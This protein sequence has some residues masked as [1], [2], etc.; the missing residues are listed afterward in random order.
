AQAVTT[1]DMRYA[2]EQIRRKTGWSS[3]VVS[4][5]VLGYVGEQGNDLS[6]AHVDQVQ[7]EKVQGVGAERE[8]Q[9]QPTYRLMSDVE[10]GVD[11]KDVMEEKILGAEVKLTLRE[12][13]RIIRQDLRDVVIQAIRKKKQLESEAITAT[14]GADF[15]VEGE[16]KE[17]NVQELGRVSEPEGMSRVGG[18]VGANVVE[19]YAVEAT[20]ME[21]EVLSMGGMVGTGA[22]DVGEIGDVGSDLLEERWLGRKLL[23]STRITITTSYSTTGDQGR[24]HLRLNL[25]VLRSQSTS[26]GGMYGKGG[27]GEFCFDIDGKGD[28]DGDEDMDDAGDLEEGE[29]EMGDLE[30]DD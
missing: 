15:G 1:A 22:V 25:R 27:G 24:L 13:L 6:V 26:L 14:L 10:K 8:K 9:Q 28:I 19:V 20:E 18:M 17:Q 4:V 30:G 29:D 5:S 16:E 3:P 21:R 2:A 23:D 11:A 12:F 7:R